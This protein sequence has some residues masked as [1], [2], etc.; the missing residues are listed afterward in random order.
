MI[1]RQYQGR[2]WILGDTRPLKIFVEDLFLD[3]LT[4]PDLTSE[5]SLFRADTNQTVIDH[6]AAVGPTDESSRVE[7]CTFQ[8]LWSFFLQFDFDGTEVIEPGE[9]YW[10]YQLNGPAS[11]V[12]HVLPFEQNIVTFWNHA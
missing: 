10:R 2:S 4:P 1:I 5:F 8:V 6:A 12:Y 3:T 11:E 9:Y 7:P